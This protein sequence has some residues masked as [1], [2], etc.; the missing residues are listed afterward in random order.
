[1][2]PLRIILAILAFTVGSLT[3][4]DRVALVL[5]NSAYPGDPLRSSKPGE[6]LLLTRL[7]GVAKDGPAMVSALETTGFTVE[8]HTNLKTDEVK[9]IVQAFAKKH[10]GAREVVFYFSGHGMSVEGETYLTGLDTDV[11]ISE[12]RREAEARLVGEDLQA[13]YAR[14]PL[15]RVT[16]KTGGAI[17]LTLI[18]ANLEGMTPS[19]LPR[20]EAKRHVRIVF[21]DACRDPFPTVENGD[22]V[23]M[24][25]SALVRKGGTGAPPSK[26]GMF[27]GFGAQAGRIGFSMENEPSLFTAAL[28][29]RIRKPG[30]MVEIFADTRIAVS[31]RYESL[32]KAK[33]A[34]EGFDQI[35]AYTDELNPK[36][37][38][39]F[40]Q[41]GT[42]PP[43]P[44]TIAERVAAATK[45]AP[46]ENELGMEFVPVPG[47][48]VLMCRTETR[49]RDWEEFMEAN[50][51]HDMS[52]GMYVM[53]VKKSAKGEYSIAWELDKN[54]SWK[55]PGFPQTGE[56]PVVGVSWEDA[57]TFFAWL[58]K[59]DGVTYRLPTDKEWSAA[60][61]SDK[62][63]WG[64]A[65][66]PPAK[67]GNYGDATYAASLNKLSDGETWSGLAGLTDGY[68]RTATADFTKF[69]ANRLGILHLGGNVWEGCEDKY[70]ASMNDSDALEKFPALKEEKYSDRT[71][72]RVLRGASWFNDA[73]VNLRS[74]FRFGVHPS[75]R[76]DFIGFRLVVLAR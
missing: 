47:T 75:D 32:V 24:S 48:S 39:S 7:S 41:G 72:F 22:V 60:V 17:P 11:D 12:A 74:S 69:T 38:F 56:H 15:K 19:S 13:E 1:M 16:A 46:F 59:K 76:S 8:Q 3:A 57:H 29:E 42:P 53:K 71:P 5:Y 61:G 45:E 6:K 66:T 26:P 44:K 51:K 25:A 2:T 4:Q 52:G 43:R 68:E 70:R 54:A 20:E 40:T 28:A 21:L 9:A 73:S 23:A 64:D 18:L 62:Y 50:P 33:I 31:D 58:S 10:S 34:P 36:V 27:I 63:P 55:S 14:L 67:A 65:E 49:L 35:P 30:T 37:K